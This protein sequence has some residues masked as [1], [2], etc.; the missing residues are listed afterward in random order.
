MNFTLS[1]PE[2]MVGLPPGKYQSRVVEVTWDQITV[3]Y[4]GRPYDPDDP[5]LLPLTVH[6]Q[7]D[8]PIEGDAR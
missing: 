4:A 2:A 6:P 7:S 8:P 1:N 3:A 5:C